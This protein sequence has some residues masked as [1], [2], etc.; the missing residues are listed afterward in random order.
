MNV[1]WIKDNNIGHEK[2]VK[3]LLDELLKNHDLDI[4]ERSV[5]GSF[6]F[7]RYINK[8]NKNYYDIIIGA[9]HKTYPFLLN[10]KKNQ[11]KQTK[12][13]AILTPT[14]KKSNFDIICAPFH[15]K[16]KFNNLTNVIFFEG[17][18]AKVSQ[19]E[20]DQKIIMVALGGKNKHYEFEDNHILS[21]IEYFLSLHP[22]KKCYIFN[23][24]RTPT[25]MN[26][27]IESLVNKNKAAIFCHFQSQDKSFQE[28]LHKSAS[29]LITRDSVNMI[30]ESLSCK[31][32][33]YLIDMKNN[34][35]KNKVVKT[36]NELISSRKIGYVDCDQMIEGISKIK[37]NKQNVYNETYA[38]VE[39]VAYQINKLL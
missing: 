32:N 21:Q 25:S 30:Y 9:G 16:Y 10:L 29:R 8:V 7:C 19:D 15:D 37:L 27:K 1:L 33:T 14:F 26:T 35:D 11:K 23:S 34:K 39:K 12:S 2:Q 6:P 20:P 38:E 28:I 3:V 36:V 4:E 5:K 17:S 24:R 18:L 22:N 31:G 13:I